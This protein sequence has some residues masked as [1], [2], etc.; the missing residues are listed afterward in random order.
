MSSAFEVRAQ[1]RRAA[2]QAHAASIGID[3][4]YISILVD[5]FYERIRADSRLGPIF[6]GEIGDQWA[7][8]MPKMKQFWS[9]VTMNT[10]VYSGKPVPA[11]TKLKGVRA[12]DFDIWLSLF[13]QTLKETAPSPE[14][15]P[16]F[17]E[18]AERIAN[19]LKLAMFGLPG[20]PQISNKTTKPA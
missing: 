11:H 10:G 4:V 19:S 3:E 14:V 13:K 17:M 1:E 12:E 16:Y 9:S 18:R 2:I 15:I 5:T 20:L 7:V 8:H 6:E